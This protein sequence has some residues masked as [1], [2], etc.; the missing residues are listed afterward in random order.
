MD[1]ING[2][3]PVDRQEHISVQDTGH[4]AESVHVVE[5]LNAARRLGV[6][7]F[8]N[9]VALLFILIEAIIGLRVLLKLIAANPQNPI[10]NFIY[11]LSDLLI[12]P[13]MGITGL[14]SLENFVLDVPAI[15]A[16]FVYALVGW[17]VVKLIWLL[18]YW[19]AARSVRT[20]EK[21]RNH[22]HH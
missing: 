19:P 21:E 4:R 12:W 10:A 22:I 5:D 18:F 17:L 7:R 20:V 6:S 16:I 8:A 13:F 1:E 3:R 14:P 2:I 11:T 9:L 15:V